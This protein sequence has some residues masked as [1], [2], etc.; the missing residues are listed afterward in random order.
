M[1]H[2]KHSLMTRLLTKELNVNSPK[3]LLRSLK[4]RFPQYKRKMM[5]PTRVSKNNV[6]T[7][8]AIL[9]RLLW[10]YGTKQALLNLL[11]IN[12]LQIKKLCLLVAHPGLLSSSDGS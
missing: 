12:S 7:L 11:S 10:D 2:G 3:L 4:T 9:I 8:L 1:L 6:P 5:K